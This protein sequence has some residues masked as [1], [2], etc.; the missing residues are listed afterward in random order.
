M[1]KKPFKTI[2]LIQILFC[3]LLVGVSILYVYKF[4]FDADF[5]YCYISYSEV[6]AIYRIHFIIL[7]FSCIMCLYYG[8][9][10]K[11]LPMRIL[12]NFLVTLSL[13]V[14]GVVISTFWSPD[15]YY[16]LSVAIYSNYMIYFEAIFFLV[17]GIYWY[18]GE[19]HRRQ[20]SY[21]IITACMLIFYIFSNGGFSILTLC[22]S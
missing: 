16:F 15:F 2:K 21:D 7:L 12:G 5:T 1:E 20:G 13:I 10:L 11:E 14:I 3:G 9:V 17:I 18:C 6:V 19:A 8:F 22:P 4:Y